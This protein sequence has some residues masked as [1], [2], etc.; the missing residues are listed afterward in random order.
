MIAVVHEDLLRRD[1]TLCTQPTASSSTSSDRASAARNDWGVPT[2][3]DLL[4]DHFT[5]WA[6]VDRLQGLAILVRRQEAEP[7]ATGLHG[8]DELSACPRA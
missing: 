2:R 7:H 8:E 4:L 5:T 1:V 3:D 6:K